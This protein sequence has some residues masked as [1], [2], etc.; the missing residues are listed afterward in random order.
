QVKKS[1]GKKGRHTHPTAAETHA[2]LRHAG[3]FNM[4]QMVSE[5]RALRASVIQLWS[6]QLTE[7]TRKDILDLTRFNE[8]IDQ[9]LVESISHYSAKLDYSRNLFLGILSHDLRGPLATARMSAQLA[10][11]IGTEHLNER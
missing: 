1:Q 5:Y 4:D 2:S 9:A 7:I 3:G 11:K 8:A 6:M 10:L